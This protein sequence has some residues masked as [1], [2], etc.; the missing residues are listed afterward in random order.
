MRVLGFIPLLYGKEYLEA[1]IKSIDP[2]ITELLIIYTE[3]PSFG[4]GSE[5]PCPESE[6]ELKDIAFATS[7]N[8]KWMNV[9]G[10]VGQEGAHRNMANIYAKEHAFDIIV[11]VDSDEVWDTDVLRKSID[12]A[13]NGN[14]QRYKTSHIGWVHFW[15]SFNY[16]CKDFFEPVRFINMNCNNGAEGVVDCKIYHFGYAQRAEIIEYKMAVHGH[17]NEIRENWLQEKFLNWKEG[18]NDVHPTSFGLWNPEIFFKDSLPPLLKNHP[19]FN[20]EII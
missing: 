11:C 20:K 13:Y 19:N 3:K 1:C 10:K 18:D 17:K 14:C 12:S 6:Q 9:T 4:Y 2:C 5:V 8:V 15:R 16:C 7:K